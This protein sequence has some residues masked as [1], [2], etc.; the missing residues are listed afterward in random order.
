MCRTK[1][2]QQMHM[3]RDAANTLGDSI[4]RTNDSTKVRVQISAPRRVDGRLLIFCSK[5]DVIMQTQV[6][7]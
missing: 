5:N 2:N 4:C 3:I 1:A 6:S 7:G